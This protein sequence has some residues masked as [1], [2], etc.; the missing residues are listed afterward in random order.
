[1]NDCGL[2]IDTTF[3]QTQLCTPGLQGYKYLSL[4][5][6]ARIFRISARARNARTFTSG[7]D[8]PVSWAISLTERSSISSNVITSRAWGESR[9]RIRAT[10]SLAASAVSEAVSGWATNLSSQSFSGS[11]KSENGASRLR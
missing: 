1:C 4:A 6:L 8:Q 11:V 2:Y 9:S 3:Y 7:T 5:I 10:R